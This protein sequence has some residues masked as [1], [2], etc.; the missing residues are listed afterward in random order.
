MAEGPPTGENLYALAIE[1]AQGLEKIDNLQDH[2]NN[3]I[4]E[5]AVRIFET[6]FGAVDEEAA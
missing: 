6:Y 4:D 5:R 1:R 2:D 3:D